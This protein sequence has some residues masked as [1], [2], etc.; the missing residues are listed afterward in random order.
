MSFLAKVTVTPLLYACG[1]LLVALLAA[2]VYAA[3][4]NS[5][6]D[7]AH[8]EKGA[9]ESSRDAAITAREAWKQRAAEG[10]DAIAAHK[11][12]TAAMRAE[13][14]RAQGEAKRRDAAARKSVA[15]AQAEAQDADRTLARM[16]AQFQAQARQPDCTR[17]LA[18][19]AIA[20]P[21]MKGY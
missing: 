14:E 13:I 8:A 18:A 6:L 20:C 2:G 5:R 1:A 17:A 15:A 4:L 11:A 19:V 9:A 16:A 21:N 3:V 7:T 10:V 12:V